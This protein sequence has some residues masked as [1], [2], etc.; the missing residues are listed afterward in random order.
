MRLIGEA[1]QLYTNPSF[2]RGYL[3]LMA[4]TLLKPA[5]HTV[6]LETLWFTQ[7]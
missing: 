1:L 7:C 2:N 6:I 3:M 5:T 4:A